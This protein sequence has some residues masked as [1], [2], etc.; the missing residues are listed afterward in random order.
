MSR[1]GPVAAAALS[2]MAHNLARAVGSAAASATGG[3]IAATPAL[4]HTTAA[5]ARCRGA[6]QQAARALATMPG[7]GLGPGCYAANCSSNR[8]PLAHNNTTAAQPHTRMVSYSSRS[9]SSASAGGAAPEAAD[10]N[11][12]DVGSDTDAEV[13]ANV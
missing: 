12:D 3:A 5:V 8:W 4:H 6:H 9:Q 13:C 10:D 7:T 11:D 2:A 1:S